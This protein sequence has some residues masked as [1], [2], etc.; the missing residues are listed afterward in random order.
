[1]PKNTPPDPIRVFVGCTNSELIPYRVLKHSIKSRT[2]AKVEICALMDFQHM[3]PRDL[4]GNIPFS[5][6]RFLIP[7]ICKYKGR[8]IYLDSDMLVLG[9][10]QELWDMGALGYEVVAPGVDVGHQ[11]VKFSVMVIDC[12][13]C[14]WDIKK[15]AALLRKE[16]V[17]YSQIMHEL[18][19]VNHKLTG[20]ARAWGRLEGVEYAEPTKLLHYTNFSRQP[21]KKRRDDPDA[22]L[23]YKEL[24]A[25]VNSGELNAFEIADQRN[26]GYVNLDPKLF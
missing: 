4:A 14:P 25:A 15:I 2:K 19:C 1:M 21:W 3:I 23:W 18:N 9:D 24:A 22:L 5:F 11:K 16:D 17:T 13:S 8:A 10:I 6:Q 12:S 20:N 26:R 7:E